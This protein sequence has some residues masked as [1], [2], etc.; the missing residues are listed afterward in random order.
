MKGAKNM[1]REVRMVPENWEHPKDVQGRYI[2]LWALSFTEMLNEYN[3][4]TVHEYPAPRPEE[5]MPEWPEQ[6]RTHM[7][8]YETCSVGTPISPAFKTAEELAHWLADNNAS[9]CGSQSASYDD[10]LATIN[11]GYAPSMVLLEGGMLVDGVAFTGSQRAEKK[12]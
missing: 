1:G 10:W 6:E 12:L 2:P 4:E 3:A 7:M 8:M 9:A 11:V 5:Y